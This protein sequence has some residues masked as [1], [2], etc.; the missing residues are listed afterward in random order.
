MLDTYLRP[1][2]QLYFLDPIARILKKIPPSM[3]TYMACLTGILVAPA[4]IVNRPLLATVL[5]LISGFLDTLDGTIA[6]I[7]DLTTEGGV[8]LDV[9]SDRIVEFA[10]IVGLLAIDPVHRGFLA[11]FMLGGCYLCMTCFFLTEVYAKPIREKAAHFSPGL[12]ERAEAFVLFLLMIWLPQYFD[13]LAIAFTLLAILTC[14][15][16]FKHLAR[17]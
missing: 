9:M 7:A 8:I 5:L 2:Y 12:M 17:R 15:I 11:L 6:R 16:H 1:I 3:I 13:K 14:Y 10:V 4:L